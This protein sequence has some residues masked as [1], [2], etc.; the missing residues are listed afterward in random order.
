MRLV[1]R[2][3]FAALFAATTTLAGPL[4]ALADADRLVID[5]VDEPTS[6]DPH[7]QW[8]PD[9]YYVYRNIFDN[10]LTRDDEGE[11]IPQIA[12][13]WEQVSDTETVFTIRDDVTFHDGSP[14]TAEDV[15]Y[16]VKRIT[17]PEFGS[18]QLSQ[19]E[20]ITNA[21]VLEDGRVK[22]TTATGY[23]ALFAQLVK[24]SIVP[25]AI[26]EEMGRE[27]FNRAPIGSGP[28]K[29]DSWQ[30]GVEV[31]LVRN[32][33]YWGDAGP[34]PAAVFRAVPDAST[35]VAN[36]TSGASDLVVGMDPDLAAQL[37]ASDGVSPVS[38][39]TERVAY[40]SVNRN[41]PGLDDPRLRK[42][43]AHAIDRELLVEGLLG[44]F[45]NPVGQMLTPAHVGWIEGLEGVPYD[46]DAARALIAEVGEPATRP[47][48]FATSPVFDQR[49]VQALQQMLGEVGLTVNIEMTDMA[50]YLQ[51][52]QSPPEQAPDLGFGRWSCACQDA[53]G[54][55]YP[56]LH[57]SSSWSRVRDDDLDVL[58]E[59]ARSEMDPDRRQELYGQIHEWIAE[60]V[61]QVPLYQAAIIYGASDNLEWSP[62][63]NESLFLN[64]MGWSE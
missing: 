12:T 28:Y 57:S 46:P 62:T 38:A 7:L 33:D 9:S 35:R 51:K 48:S 23:P 55:L 14:L 59:S 53:D 5:L 6:L 58:L 44:G 26:V 13:E 27:A 16:S 41:K 60:E 1:T 43:I 42:A 29:F 52:S 21:E 32:D 20:S 24:L 40:L 45:D 47:F 37:E 31:G 56:L 39:L 64:R 25:K 63:P 15:V 54:V 36:L 50:T 19:F 34:F 11:I 61:P 49:I 2:T 22:L 30:R 3:L 4:A 8:N 17:D 18:P 10:L